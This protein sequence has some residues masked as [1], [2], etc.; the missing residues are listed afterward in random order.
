MPHLK[1]YI[2]IVY[3]LDS[4]VLTGKI[5][6]MITLLLGKIQDILRDTFCNMAVSIFILFLFISPITIL[7]TSLKPIIY[8]KS[9]NDNII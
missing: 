3:F 5:L 7:K 6:E 1:I 2:H 9:G 4:F 8:L